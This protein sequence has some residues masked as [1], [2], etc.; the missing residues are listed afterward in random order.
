M[1]FELSEEHR[2]LKDLVAKFVDNELIPLEPNVLARDARGEP[3]ALSDEELEPLYAKCKELGLWGLDVP[4]E[5]G[6]ANLPNVALAA[7]NEELGRTAV[8]FTFP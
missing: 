4:E 7:I 8:P 3:A 2:M 1:E 5:V 6:G